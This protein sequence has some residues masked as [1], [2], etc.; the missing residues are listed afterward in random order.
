MQ[1]SF[2]INFQTFGAD[3]RHRDRPKKACD[4]KCVGMDKFFLKKYEIAQTILLYLLRGFAN[5]SVYYSDDV[6]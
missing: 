1:F 5:D 3:L 4:G 6:V 2:F